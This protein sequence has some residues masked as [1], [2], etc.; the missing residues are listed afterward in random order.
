MFSFSGAYPSLGGVIFNANTGSDLDANQHLILIKAQ[1]RAPYNL[2][3][4]P[5]KAHRLR[6]Y[7]I[8]NRRDDGEELAGVFMLRMEPIVK[9]LA[10]EVEAQGTQAHP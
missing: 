6:K 4:L 10:D 1:D 8:L 3:D 9:T 7:G 5:R 2:I